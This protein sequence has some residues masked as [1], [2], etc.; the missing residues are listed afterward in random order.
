VS[1]EGKESLTLVKRKKEEGKPRG[2]EAGYIARH[3]RKTILERLTRVK[4]QGS[5]AGAMKIPRN[6]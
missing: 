1:L 2:D 3:K 5:N 6:G 4:Q